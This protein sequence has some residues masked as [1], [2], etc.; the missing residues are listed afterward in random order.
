[1]ALT[2]RALDRMEQLAGDAF[3]RV[4]SLRLAVDDAERDDLR[5]EY[6]ALREDG[7]A[8]DWVDELAAAARPALR[9]RDPPSA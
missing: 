3:R 7:F 8:V 6:D 5:R 2:E 9:R 4:G 1:M